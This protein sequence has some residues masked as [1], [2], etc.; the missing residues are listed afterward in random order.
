MSLKRCAG[1]SASILVISVA[2]ALPAGVAA[3][4]TPTGYL[5]VGHFVPG[6]SSVSVYL[7]NRLLVGSLSYQQ[8]TS[9]AATPAGTHTLRVSAPAAN[10]RPAQEVS[11][12]ET[13]EPGQ[14]ATVLIVASSNGSFHVSSFADNLAQPPPGDA[15]I[16][17]IDTLAAVPTLAASL[18][19]VIDPPGPARMVV[20]ATGQGQASP[21]SDVPAGSYNVAF[22]NAG[23]GATVLTGQDWPVTAGTV[24]SLVVLQGSD[25][26]TLEVLKD[27]VGASSLP[28]GGMQTGA[29]GMATRSE[30]TG[31]GGL[32]VG[33]GLVVAVGLG[34]WV[35]PRRSRI[36]LALAAVVGAVVLVGCSS[37]HAPPAPVAVAPPHS[38]AGTGQVPLFAAAKPSSAASPVNLSG[39]GTAD[40]SNQPERINAPTVGID[41]AIVDLGRLANGTMQV[42]AQFGVAGWY[43]QG[44]PPGEPGPAV[45]VGHVDN[46]TG[47][48]VFW[49]L[50]K[51]R[52]GDPV[53]VTTARGL[54]TF[55]VTAVESVPKDAFPTESVFGP[56]ADPELRLITCSGQFDRST[57]H[58]LDN[59]I[60]FARLISE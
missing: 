27:A 7:D 8:V 57:G 47:P 22:T 13:V 10:G 42:P 35:L 33:L 17:I 2:L 49:H 28:A 40:P 59:T 55:R 18:T 46:T 48:A 1:F 26:S 37:M 32:V 56:V 11:A 39:D 25:G 3:A 23:T 43:D 20:P 52:P 30:T 45:I 9:Y 16:R 51:L 4:S 54:E 31:L 34:A 19:A 29:G 41:A 12:T 44:P 15:K 50:S 53:T 14:S 6:V 60:V 24:A 21:Y 5:R 38:S 36:R 58:Y